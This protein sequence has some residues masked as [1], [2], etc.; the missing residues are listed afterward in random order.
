MDGIRVNFLGTSYAEIAMLHYW[1]AK[2]EYDKLLHIEYIGDES[3]ICE[4]TIMKNAIVAETFSAMALESYFNNCQ[5]RNYFD[6]KR[7]SEMTHI[8][9]HTTAGISAGGTV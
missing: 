9:G 1:G 5:R 2:K 6:R 7:R 4:R 8:A 3:I